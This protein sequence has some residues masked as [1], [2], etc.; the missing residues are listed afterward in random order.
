MAER[1]PRVPATEVTA[2]PGGSAGGGDGSR[3]WRSLRLWQIQWVRDLMIIGAVAGV[4]Y[5]GYV[6]SVVTVPMLVAL[7][8]AYLFEP[9]VRRLTPPRSR[10]FS[11][12]GMAVMIILSSVLVVVVP[13]LVGVTFAGI[14]AVN[15]AGVIARNV[16]LVQEAVRNPD[17]PSR[18]KAVPEGA[19]HW[20]AAELIDLE[21]R[22]KSVEGVPAARPGGESPGPAT[23][24]PSPAQQPAGPAPGASPAGAASDGEGADVASAGADRAEDGEGAEEA[25]TLPGL[26]PQP[27]SPRSGVRA[28]ADIAL[29]WIRAN[30]GALGRRAIGT[31]AE[32]V[33]FAARGLVS[34]GMLVFGALLTAFF[35]YFFCTGWGRVLAFW[36]SL[37]PE[38]KKSRT[39]ELLG[40][41]DAVIAG[42]VRGRLTIAFVLAGVITV[43]YWLIGVPMPLV[44]GPVVG[45]LVL[46]PYGQ[47]VGLPIAMFAM[48][49]QP[50]PVA[51]QQEWWWIVF[52]PIGVY[53]LGQVLDDYILSPLIQGR[54]TGMDTPTILFA[55]IAGG[56]LA[57]VYGLLL[58]IPTAACV[59]ILLREVFWPRFRA[60]A[61]G[62]ERDFLPISGGDSGIWPAEGGP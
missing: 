36:E 5:L 50:S 3:D 54:S 46:V 32:A 35:F 4:F 2:A 44:F 51:W 1:A 16:A 58:A 9:L 49:M 42:F 45:A 55:S 48:W 40:M 13:V 22:E 23:P 43:A 33:G 47:T 39:V 26:P 57:G 30:A 24:S 6:L 62:K 25:G 37:I 12:P 19:W 27:L 15:Y 14:Q 10:V 28:A 8:L 53:A 59:K 56:V 21:R 61:E 41:M 7:L 17:D 38:R 34:A 60:W 20:I 18:L 29:A 11:R 31:G 52:A